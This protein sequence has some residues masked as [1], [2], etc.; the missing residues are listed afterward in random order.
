MRRWVG[1]FDRLPEDSPHRRPPRPRDHPSTIPH[2][3]AV[4]LGH[5]LA[6]VVA[7]ERIDEGVV[8]TLHEVAVRKVRDLH[9]D[10]TS[11]FRAYLVEALLRGG[12]GTERAGHAERLA[13][14]FPRMI[15]YPGT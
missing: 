6:T 11:G 13:A 2:A 10:E 9:G 3:A 7:S 4:A 14:L 5:T 1:L 8:E 15:A 12:Y